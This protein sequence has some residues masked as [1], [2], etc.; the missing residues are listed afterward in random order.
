MKPVETNIAAIVMI[1]D[2]DDKVLILKR[3]PEIEK[4]WM[5]GKWSLPGGHLNEGETT[6]QGAIR[7]IFEE[8]E[9]KISNLKF[10]KNI[11]HVH[12]FYTKTFS[13]KV[14]LDGYENTDYAWV[15]K[16]SIYEYDIVPDLDKEV[17]HV[18]KHFL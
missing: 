4:Q 10:Y 9:L 8:T 15:S 7:E 16:D 3:N 17:E 5:P 2:Q 13:G 11:K 6:E 12:F 14:M 18:R 1:F